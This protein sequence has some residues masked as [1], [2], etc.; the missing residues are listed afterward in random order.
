MI[1]SIFLNRLFQLLT[2]VKKSVFQN[3][4]ISVFEN[5]S[6][7]NIIEFLNYYSIYIYKYKF[8]YKKDFL[9]KNIYILSSTS[10][11]EFSNIYHQHLAFELHISV[12][13][14]VDNI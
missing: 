2:K 6:G 5:S 8:L 14:L 13:F 3:L 12:N 4:V 10:R 1:I 9:K 7:D 11:L